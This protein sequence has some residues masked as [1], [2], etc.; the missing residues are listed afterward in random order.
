MLNKKF[1]S[2]ALAN[3]FYLLMVIVYGAFVRATGSG[4]GCGNHWPLCGGELIPRDPGIATLIELTHRVTSGLS[5]PFAFLIYIMARADA[6]VRRYALYMVIFLVMEGLLGAGLVRLE[7]V[8]DNRSLYRGVSM[9]LHLI[10]TF[11]LMAFASLTWFAS[12]FE[13]PRFAGDDAL[14]KK[15]RT[16]ALMFVLI[17]ITGALTALGDTLFPVAKDHSQTSSHLF[18][19]LRV[20]HP[21]VAILLSSL[22]IYFVVSSPSNQ[23][24]QVLRTR[25]S[26]WINR[27]T[28]VSLL[29]LQLAVGCINIYLWAP[30]WLQ[31]FHLAIAEIIWIVFICWAWKVL[32]RV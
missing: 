7:H 10:N 27:N 2:L 25:A 11:C 31:L 20:F 24:N 1:S 26:A 12:L 17:G 23:Q 9:S 16:M 14:F 3:L 19:Q 32:K 22:F 15:F 5:L 30:I 6:R 8:A 21:F 18:T 29:L 28:L 13:A 4:A